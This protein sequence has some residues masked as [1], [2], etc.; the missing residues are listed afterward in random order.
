MIKKIEVTSTETDD[1]EKN[2]CMTLNDEE[3][4]EDAPVTLLIRKRY[5]F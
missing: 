1:H 3:K 4:N 5:L 2:D